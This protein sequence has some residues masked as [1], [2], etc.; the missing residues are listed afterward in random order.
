MRIS[1]DLALFCLLEPFLLS[2][3]GDPDQPSPFN[4]FNKAQINCLNLA[5][6]ASKLFFDWHPLLAFCERAL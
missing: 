4:N 1:R 5:L 3:T 6:S 2:T